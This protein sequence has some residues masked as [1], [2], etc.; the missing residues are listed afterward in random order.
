MK[1]SSL[2]YRTNNFRAF[3]PIAKI[4]QSSTF[5]IVL[6]VL[7]VSAVLSTYEFCRPRVS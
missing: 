7:I 3:Q 5:A 1:N 2:K 4:M 6:Y